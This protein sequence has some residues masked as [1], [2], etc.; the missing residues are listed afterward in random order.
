[1]PLIYT[2]CLE[3]Y[4]CGICNVIICVNGGSSSVVFIM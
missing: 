3:E 1:M 4:E 2:I